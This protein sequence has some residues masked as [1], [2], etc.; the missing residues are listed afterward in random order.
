[1]SVE[2]LEH[3]LASHHHLS[4]L[5]VGDY[6]IEMED[7]PLYALAQQ[8]QLQQLAVLMDTSG[9]DEEERPGMRK[10]V[11]AE[12]LRLGEAASVRSVRFYPTP[13]ERVVEVYDDIVAAAEGTYR[14]QLFDGSEKEVDVS[15]VPQDKAERIRT[16]YYMTCTA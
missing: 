4:V 3:V 2:P 15:M 11:I 12:G 14:V 6:D 16:G 10:K 9:R 8:T 7:V 13:P 5:A 1:M